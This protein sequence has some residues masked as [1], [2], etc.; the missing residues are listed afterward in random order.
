M[1]EKSVVLWIGAWP[2]IGCTCSCLQEL[3]THEDSI[4]CIQAQGAWLISSILNRLQAEMIYFATC[5]PVS[6]MPFWKE[7]AE[8]KMVS[9]LD[10]KSK[11]P[12]C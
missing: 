10:F 11:N 2:P 12:K 8:N 3:V 4:L 6:Y 5:V 7:I 1:T 9:P